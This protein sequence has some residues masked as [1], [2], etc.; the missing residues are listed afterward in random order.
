MP[1]YVAPEHQSYID[2]NPMVDY[3]YELPRRQG[4][5]N[6]VIGNSQYVY[7]NKSL[8]KNQTALGNELMHHN[9]QRLDNFSGYMHD[10]LGEVVFR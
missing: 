3:E 8:K 10:D 7:N 2:E 6:R 4:S 1:Q 5:S 9:A